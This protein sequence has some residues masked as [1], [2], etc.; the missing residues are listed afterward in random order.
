MKYLIE[1]DEDDV[2]VYL[3]GLGELKYKTAAKR[4]ARLVDQVQ[5]QRDAAD[6]AAA[7]PPPVPAAPAL[8]IVKE[9]NQAER[10]GRGGNY[11]IHRLRSG[12]DA[13]EH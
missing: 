8:A 9:Y 11:G 5:A 4:V 7:Q 6:K 1:M 13:G 3:A 10:K 2:S 12:D